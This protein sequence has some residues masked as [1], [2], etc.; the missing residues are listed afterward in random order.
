MRSRPRLWLGWCG[1]GSCR[2]WLAPTLGLGRRLGLEINL[3]GCRR[4]GLGLAQTMGLESRL[5]LERRWLGL[6][7]TMG[8]ESW[9]W[10]A[11]P[12]VG[13]A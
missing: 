9:L 7:Q 1:P 12:W 5:G 11:R 6:A 3:P 4:L 13:L 2:L 10:L 8:L